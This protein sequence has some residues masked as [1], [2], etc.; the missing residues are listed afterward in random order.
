MIRKVIAEDKDTVIDLI[1]QFKK[2]ALDKTKV[3]F[4]KN[5]LSKRIDMSIAQDNPCIFICYEGNVGVG[6]ISGLIVKSFFDDNQ[7]LA[8]E[9][10]WYISENY[11]GKSYGRDLLRKFEEYAKSK[12]ASNIIMI[13][14]HYSINMR[15]DKLLD[16]FYTK[17]GYVKLETHYI[18]NLEQGGG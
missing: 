5:T 4:N 6:I 18:K 9:L 15:K 10:V 16:Y 8:M 12:G 14:G 2:E 11:R 7:I 1:W 17:N 3:S 13:A